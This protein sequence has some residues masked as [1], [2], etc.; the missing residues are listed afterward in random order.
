MQHPLLIDWSSVFQPSIGLAEVM[1]RG[2]IMYLALF[3]IM[4][5]IARRQSGSF[6][7][8]DLLVIVLIA[9]AAQNALG[10]EYQSVTEGI[11]LVMTIIGWEYLLD[12]LAW[13]FPT[14]RPILKAP[15]LKLVE[16]GRPLQENLRR[17]MLSESEL[18]GSLREHG[19]RDFREV[20]AAYIEESGKLSV[21]K[22]ESK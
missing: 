12:W 3:V 19:V 2:S 22:I 21:I 10:K 20:N 1:V 18:L 17:E 8:A 7:T 15:P 4:R 6:G 16:H 9:D 13:R 11:V 14:L 5:F